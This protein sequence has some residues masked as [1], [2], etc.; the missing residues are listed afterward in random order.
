MKTMTREGV[1]KMICV[2]QCLED[3]SKSLLTQGNLTAK[4][5]LL[6]AR[7]KYKDITLDDIDEALRVLM[8]PIF[9]LIQMQGVKYHAVGSVDS[10]KRLAKQFYVYT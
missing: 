2:L 6:L 8:I 7:G 4:E 1:Q 5:I 9:G 10:F 3:Q